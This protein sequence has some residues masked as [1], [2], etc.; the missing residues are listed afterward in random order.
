MEDISRKLFVN[1]PL[2]P[3][4][5]DS[6]S[7]PHNAASYSYANNVFSPQINKGE[8]F[9]MSNLQQGADFLKGAY[10]AI[11]DSIKTRVGEEVKSRIQNKVG[12]FVRNLD[13]NPSTRTSTSSSGYALSLAPDPAKTELDSGI[14]PNTYVSEILDAQEFNC[15]PLHMTCVRLEFPSTAGNKLQSYFTKLVSFELQTRAQANV[16]F[17]IDI[18]NT[19]S[20]TKILTAVNSALNAFQCYFYYR[21]VLSYHSFY[22]NKN[23]GMDEIR[24]S[25]TPQM[26]E[27][28]S[29][30]GRRLSNTPFPPKLYELVRYLSNTYQSGDSQGS[31]LL[32]LCPHPPTDKMTDLTWIETTIND[33]SQANNNNVYTL[34]RRA[35]PQWRP[36]VLKDVNPIP[37]F[38]KNFLTIF[39]NLPSVYKV[40]A[41]TTLYQPIQSQTSAAVP[42]NSFTNTLDGVAFALTAIR[43]G[44]TWQPS[45]VNPL[46]NAVFTNNRRSYYQFGTQEP[47]FY[48][49][50]T[51][52][53]LS[54]ARPETN[55]L[56]DAGT[57]YINLH[58]SGADKCLQVSADSIRETTVKVI[59]YLM[60]LDTV[61]NPDIRATLTGRNSNK[62][63]P[64]SGNKRRSKGKK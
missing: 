41:T 35:V 17:N 51:T 64:K 12:D 19:F 47:A 45:L 40:D 43:I 50:A 33:L 9:Q 27:S 5:K 24:K 2:P 13:D 16:G 62:S 59:D 4:R 3:G 11:P 61:I 6:W 49:V 58:L 63:A 21:S 53:F 34:M 52:P 28:L 42:Y 30:L 54:R 31:P 14:W 18:S 46:T 55:Q 10:E 37:A 32:K 7:Q 8:S 39:A 57:S 25:I 20:E 22:G 38:D 56:I 44:T 1:I 48:D 26:L 29:Q 23:E 60:S 15:S 36:G